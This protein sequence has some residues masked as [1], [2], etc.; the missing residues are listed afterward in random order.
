MTPILNSKARY[1]THSEAILNNLV[2]VLFVLMITAL[3]RTYIENKGNDILLR[4]NLSSYF[5]IDDVTTR[6]VESLRAYL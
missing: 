4:S 5:V 1:L 3:T 6:L 2:V